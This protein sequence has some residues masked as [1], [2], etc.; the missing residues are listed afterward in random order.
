MEEGKEEKMVRTFL[1]AATGNQGVRPLTISKESIQECLD[2]ETNEQHQL[3]NDFIYRYLDD[4]AFELPGDL[5]VERYL[6]R[7]FEYVTEVL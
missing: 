4:V 3:F 7:P 2:L 1:V 5:I 6:E